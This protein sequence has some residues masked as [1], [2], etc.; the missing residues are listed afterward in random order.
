VC[1]AGSPAEESGVAVGDQIV[2][3]NKQDI[4]GHTHLQ[5]VGTIKKVRPPQS[6]TVL[7]SLSS[8]SWMHAAE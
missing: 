6:Y 8:T 3:V 4:S 5:L 7:V 2:S 1:P